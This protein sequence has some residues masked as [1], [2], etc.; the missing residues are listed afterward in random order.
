M[1]FD[2][3]LQRNHSEP[4]RL[5]KSITNISTVSGTLKDGTS[6]IDPVIRIQCSLS[7]VANCNYMT[8]S[9][10]GRSYFVRDIRS[11]TNNIVEFTCHV[12]VLS[13]YKNGIRSNTGI[14][15]RQ[16]NQWNLYLNDGS[17]KVY[18]NPYV[19]TKE[20]PSGFSTQE[21]VFAIAGS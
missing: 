20:F 11:L 15:R 17:L 4:I 21:F 14:T 8:I 16:E 10:F 18:Q 1:S 5:D 19:I 9:T 13:T 6:L 7:D 2:I 3:I 12:D